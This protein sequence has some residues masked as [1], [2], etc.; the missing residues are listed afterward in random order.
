LIK[1]KYHLQRNPECSEYFDNTNWSKNVLIL[2]V[3]LLNMNTVIVTQYYS[4]N[5]VTKV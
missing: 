3:T 5:I 4:L 1:L 2:E